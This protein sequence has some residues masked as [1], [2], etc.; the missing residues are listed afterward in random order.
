MCNHIVTYI[1]NNINLQT[2]YTI[3]LMFASED[4][5]EFYKK[6]INNIKSIYTDCNT[7]D[8]VLEFLLKVKCKEE[9]QTL[10]DKV[11]K[12]NSKFVIES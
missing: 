8:L 4:N 12:I 5:V 3:K 10:H 2:D 9:C 6:N 11:Y 7:N 1:A